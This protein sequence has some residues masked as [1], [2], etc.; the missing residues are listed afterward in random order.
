MT[1][2]AALVSLMWASVA[3]A[4]PKCAPRDQIAILLA[5]YG[6]VQVGYG[7]R[8]QG[9]IIEFW[10]SETGAFTFL[11]TRSDGSACIVAVGTNWEVTTPK[12]GVPG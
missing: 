11:Q 7:I 3:V 5:G 1:R 12:A 6:E 4:Q 2:L 10:M 9:Q 8:S